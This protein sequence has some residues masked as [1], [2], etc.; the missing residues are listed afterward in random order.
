MNAKFINPVL[1]AVQDVF[2]TMVGMNVSAGKPVLNKDKMP[3]YEVN[4]RIGLSGAVCGAICVSLPEALSLRIA[5]W[6]L[7]EEYKELDEDSIDALKEIT[8]MIAGNAKSNFPGD[9]VEITVP[10]LMLGRNSDVYPV[11]LPIISI[12]FFADNEKFTVDIALKATS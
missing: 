10:D 12:P 1:D 5:S 6:M 7:E 8:N 4:G 3:G 9:N 11:G 2:K